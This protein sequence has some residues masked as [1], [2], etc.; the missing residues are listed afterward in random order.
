MESAIKKADIML[1]KD[2]DLEKWSV[3]ACDQFTS[4]KEYWNTLKKQ[5]GD[6]KS[7]LNLVLPEVYL[8]DNADER[9]KKINENIKEYIKKEVFATYKDSFILTVRKTKYVERR[10]GL[11]GA[12]DL[13][14]YEYSEK[15]S[16]LVRS[17]EATIEERIP[18]RLKIRKDAEMEFPHI[19]IL[20][21]DEKKEILETLYEDREKYKKLY[22][23]ELN[24][25]GG[26]IEGYLIEDT[27]PVIEKFNK[28]LE[29]ERQIK[30]YGTDAKLLFAVGDGNHSLATAK[31]HWN[32]VKKTLT[33]EEKLTH[34]S[35]YALCE[36]NNVY[37]DGIYFEPIYR[38][39]KG[40][41]RQNFINNFTK[42]LKYTCGVFDGEKIR[43][44]N[45]ESNLALAIKTVDE[46]IKSY[47]SENG[48]S[49]DYVHGESNLCNL[50]K[51]GEDSV[52][53]TFSKLSKEDLFKSVSK[54]GAFPRKTFSMG[55]GVEK[56]YYLEGRLLR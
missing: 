56:R 39:V 11:I 14:A 52:G 55:E 22:D 7:T 47:I 15:S 49:V 43:V 12:V 31:T 42:N 27:E 3:I 10:I 32:N 8:N 28:L 17:T 37:D 35:R 25:G 53:I 41:N 16:A 26:H 46:F 45:R 1:P 30:K 20:F 36:F 4:E 13:E 19:M 34:P 21:D 24:M 51:S 44:Y 54:N 18:P 29:S 48:G 40:V 33:E 5:V 2:C 23:F 6:A 9:I 50:V 38:Y